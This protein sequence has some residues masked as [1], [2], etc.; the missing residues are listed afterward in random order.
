MTRTTTNTKGMVEITT[1]ATLST[2]KVSTK[3]N[4]RGWVSN[5]VTVSRRL[6][7]RWVQPSRQSSRLAAPLPYRIWGKETSPL[8]PTPN[9]SS[10]RSGAETPT[11]SQSPL[12]HTSA[13]N[14]S[15]TATKTTMARARVTRTRGKKRMRMRMPHFS[16]SQMF[17]NKRHPKLHYRI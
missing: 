12:S 14:G 9:L 17:S 7:A 6:E 4:L 16:P 8:L 13:S 2:H 1:F 10:K 15:I 11:P 3:C 5:K